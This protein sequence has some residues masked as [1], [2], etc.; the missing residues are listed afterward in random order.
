MKKDIKDIKVQ[1]RMTL[2][3]KKLLEKLVATNKEL[4]ISKILRDSIKEKCEKLG[5]KLEDI[6]GVANNGNVGSFIIG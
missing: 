2:D 5:I 6:S 4:T 3:E 1:I